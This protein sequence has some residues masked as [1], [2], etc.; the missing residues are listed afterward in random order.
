[1]L[2]TKTKVN[3]KRTLK[4]KTHYPWDVWA[5]GSE[6]VIKMGANF[7][8]KPRI[9]ACAIY[10]YARRHKKKAIVVVDEVKKTVTFCIK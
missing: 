9:M 4:T 10:S 6:R 3:K 2:S 7:S 5:D 1:M 8:A